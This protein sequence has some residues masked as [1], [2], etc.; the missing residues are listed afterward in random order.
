MLHS[1]GGLLRHI[2][3]FKVETR[4]KGLL[5]R[6]LYLLDLRLGCKSPSLQAC[7]HWSHFLLVKI[8]HV[9]NKAVSD[10]VHLSIK[11]DLRSLYNTCIDLLDLSRMSVYFDV[12]DHFRFPTIVNKSIIPLGA[13]A[14]VL[15]E[16]R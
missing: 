8:D 10:I 15:L 1:R 3:S 6:G 7:N 5:Q 2:R 16:V 4:Y 14:R 9:V 11:Q 12:Q 13:L